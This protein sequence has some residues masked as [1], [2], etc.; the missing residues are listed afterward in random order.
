MNN[1]SV[2]HL[3][4]IEGYK[5]TEKYFYLLE[6]SKTAIT[7]PDSLTIV[8]SFT[9]R[10][11]ALLIDQL[12]RNSIPY[13]NAVDK[14]PTDKFIKAFKPVYYYNV[15][16]SVKTEDTLII[17]AYDTSI[18]SLDNLDRLQEHYN[19]DII[20]NASLISFPLDLE[21]DTGAPDGNMWRNLNSGVVYGKTEKLLTFYH[22][23]SDYINNN[24][25]DWP[26]IKTFEQWWLIDFL[27]NYKG[28][29]KIGVDYDFKAFELI[30]HMSVEKTDKGY[31]CEP[32]I[33]FKR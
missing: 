21:Y 23:L 3:N 13:V 15:L 20:Y 27:N 22:E 6:N 30:Q 7:K 16:Q 2:I 10:K 26:R 5:N 8:T 9:D 1:T 14:I 33:G 19:R 18:K 28:N 4:S 31:K 24:Y 29:I 25:N 17:D 32:K 11:D 12:E